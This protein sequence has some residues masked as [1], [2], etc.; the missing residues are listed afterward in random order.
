MR[1][2]IQVEDFFERGHSGVWGGSGID[3]EGGHFRLPAGVDFAGGHGGFGGCEV[4]S[5]AIAYQQAIFAKKE[6]VVVPAGFVQ[7]LEHFGPDLLVALL[8]LF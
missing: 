6:A 2:S 5:F 8:V 7:S 1:F 3:E 4:E